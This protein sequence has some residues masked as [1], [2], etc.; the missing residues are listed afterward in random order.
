MISIDGVLIAS[1]VLLGAVALRQH[2][3]L[4]RLQKTTGDLSRVTELGTRTA[5]AVGRALAVE[6][7]DSMLGG[8][9]RPGGLP[10]E[11]RGAEAEDVV[12]SLLFAGQP[13]GSTS[14][15]ARSTAFAIR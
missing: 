15:W 1:V 9:A 3:I 10:T 13:T 6:R 4:R 7:A 2:R 14:R 8:E 5:L 11:P 12:L